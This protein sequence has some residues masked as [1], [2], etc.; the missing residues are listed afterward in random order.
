[1]QDFGSPLPRCHAHAL[2]LLLLP[3]LSNV[4]RALFL[5]QPSPTVLHCLP[6]LL[7][8]ACALTLSLVTSGSV[9]E[10]ILERAK[11]KM[12][13]DHLVIQRMDTSGRMVL[14]AGDKGGPA[15]GAT[16]KKM[17]GKDELAAIL[18]FGAE[19]LFKAENQKPEVGGRRAQGR[20][21]H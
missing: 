21:G 14:D 12:V 7:P 11:K 10:D 20:G 2:S 6:L 17:F 8:L 16:A 4:L 13:L 9:E 3:P 1:M 5:K 18:R 15:G 19:E